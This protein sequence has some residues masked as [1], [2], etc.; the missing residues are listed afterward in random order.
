M[1]VRWQRLI[2][3]FVYF[4]F[5]SALVFS[6]ERNP[7]IKK[8]DGEYIIILPEAMEEALQGY[9][10]EFIL[11]RHS[12][13]LPSLIKHYPF[14]IKQTPFAVIGDFN[15]DRIL[16]VVLEGHNR[17]NDLLICILSYAKSFKIVEIKRNRLTNPKEEW[18]GMGNHKEYG[19][20]VY[21]TFVPPRKID[22]PFEKRP[23]KLKTDAF[24]LNWFE[25][26]SVLYYFENDNF[27]K[28]TTGD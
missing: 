25:K 5:G 10:P 9:D 6:G 15:G 21:L 7:V 27:L 14:S 12:D 16:D 2:T 11:R 28:Y 8:I 17:S 24:E 13:Y 18:Y 4:I 20:W 26:A 1:W 22:S 23:L 19:L 3:I